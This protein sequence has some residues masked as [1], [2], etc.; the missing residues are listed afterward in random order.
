MVPRELL[1][2]VGDKQVHSV[3]GVHARKEIEA[4]WA[5]EGWRS[6]IR[7]GSLRT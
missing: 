3:W 4:V 5:D 1:C 2:L 7:E 6:G